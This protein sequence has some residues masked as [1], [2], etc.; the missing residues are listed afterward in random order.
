MEVL[1]LPAM[2]TQ[3]HRAIRVLLAD[4]HPIVMSGCEMA[5]ASRGITTVGRATSATE[6]ARQFEELRPD[7]LVLDIKFGQSRTG[8]DVA[9]EVLTSAPAAKIVFWSQCDQASVIREAY[10]IG[11]LA[12]VTKLA[13]PEELATAIE[14][15]ASGRPYLQSAVAEKFAHQALL[16]ERTPHEL[17]TARELTVFKLIARGYTNQEIASELRLAVRTISTVSQA[18]KDKLGAQR[19]ADLTR[20]AVRHGL[21][22]P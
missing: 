12:Y 16:G 4:D 6:A 18:V 5:L 10:R 17:L 15:A 2:Q 11:A 19:A 13:L 3:P 9:Q 20:I 8:F 1:N 14:S 21:V 7:V 22:E